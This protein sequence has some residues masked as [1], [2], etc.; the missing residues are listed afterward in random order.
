MHSVLGAT[1]AVEFSGT[2]VPIDFVEV[3]S[4][5]FE[6]WLHEP[7]VLRRLSYHY[8]TGEPLPEDIIQK[9]CS[10][11][12]FGMGYFIQRQ[13]A[14]ADLALQLFGKDPEIAIDL[15]DQELRTAY[16][17][18]IQSNK[19]DH[20]AASFGHLAGY[21]AL[22]YSYLWSKVYAV[23]LFAHIKR[24]GLFST[25]TGNRFIQAV[26]SRGGTVDPQE[27]LRDFCGQEPE[28]ELFFSELGLLRS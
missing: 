7:E 1:H 25:E 6:E 8:Q 20:F 11:R 26:L 15:C 14:L 19:K 23:I 10:L 2:N 13:S 22:Y 28:L 9:L 4:Q 3:P 27:M 5:M 17:P 12:S 18:Y 16:L 21:G 24:M